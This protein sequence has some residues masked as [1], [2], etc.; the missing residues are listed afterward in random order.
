M[1]SYFGKFYNSSISDKNKNIY[2]SI[3]W[4]LWHWIKFDVNEILY[5]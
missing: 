4:E 1:Y 3:V 2:D 5:N